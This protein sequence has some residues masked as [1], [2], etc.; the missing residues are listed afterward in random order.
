LSYIFG[1]SSWLCLGESSGT[2]VMGFKI[3]SPKMAKNWRF[4]LKTL[5]LCKIH[6]FL[7]KTF[8]PKIGNWQK[9][10]PWLLHT[11][12]NIVCHS[13]SEL[14]QEFHTWSGMATTTFCHGESPGTSLR[15]G[16][17]STAETSAAIG[18]WTSSASTPPG[19]TNF[20]P[21]S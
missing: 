1:M 21:E 12:V 8:L 18:A 13:R 2:D 5:K 10:T 6:L 4:R 20:L 15:T 16:T 19:S 14:L 3:V 17:G 7:G 9:Y 11:K